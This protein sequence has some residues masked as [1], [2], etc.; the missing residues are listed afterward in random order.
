MTVASNPDASLNSPARAGGE[1]GLGIDAGGTQ[2]RWAL[3]NDA[4]QIIADGFVGGITALQIATADGLLTLQDTLQA[5]ASAAAVHGSPARVRVGLT[6]FG[7]QSE[8][9]DELRRLMARPFGLL[10]QDI[11]LSNDIELAYLDNFRPGEG[12]LVYSGTGSIAAYIEKNGSFHRAGGH[13]GVLDDA[14]GG[15]WIAREALRHI[16]RS[17]DERPG[18]WRQSTLALKVFEYIGG[19][20]WSSS[21]AFI[22][23]G[24]RGQVGM[25]A[26]AVAAAADSD[27]VAFGI[28]KEAGRELAR[29]AV[30]LC[31]RYGIKPIILAGRVQ[32]LHPI[33]A[34]SMRNSLPADYSLRQSSSQAH[35]AAARMASNYGMRK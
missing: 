18:S 17:E 19:N 6:G 29:L 27:P 31:G 4:G 7:G 11:I 2:T 26:L 34:Q 33:I 16:W 30:A 14:G 13:G 15:F 9:A 22:Y 28:L 21:R 5:L 32:E 10:P 23:N 24:T 8:V 35:F 1:L 12:Y 3:A 20:D 25:L